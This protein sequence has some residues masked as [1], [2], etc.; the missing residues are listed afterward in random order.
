[1]TRE[2]FRTPAGGIAPEGSQKLIARLEVLERT[3]ERAKRLAAEFRQG[4]VTNAVGD[5]HEGKMVTRV[6][7]RRGLD[8][9]L[10]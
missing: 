2:E 3:E 9:G 1:M 5:E 6:E 8:G 7:A 10:L 4:R